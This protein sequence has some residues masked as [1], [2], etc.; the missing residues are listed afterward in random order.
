MRFL[1]CCFQ[2]D[3]VRDLQALLLFKQLEGT[4]SRDDGCHRPGA[5]MLSC[6]VAAGCCGKGVHIGMGGAGLCTVADQGTRP[7]RPSE[8]GQ[9]LL[10]QFGL[11]GMCCR[12]QCLVPSLVGQGVVQ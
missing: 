5:A 9:A 11:A 1:R 3:G 2:G 12:A 4:C 10:Q 6:Y 8:A 7:R